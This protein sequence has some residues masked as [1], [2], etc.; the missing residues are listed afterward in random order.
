MRLLHAGLIVSDLKIAARFYEGVL[1]LHRAER[2]NLSF[3][4]IFYALDD[5][6]QIHLMQLDNPY[7]GCAMPEHGGR[8]RHLAL[9]VD[10]LETIRV[11]LNAAGIAYTMSKSGRAALFCR[12]PDDNAIELCSPGESVS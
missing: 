8:D 4:G 10:D 12:D 2:P 3:A 7:V 11:R 1:G 6:R 9:G 5:G